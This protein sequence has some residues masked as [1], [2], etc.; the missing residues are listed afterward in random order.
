MKT[1][2]RLILIIILVVLFGTIP[3]SLLSKLFEY[4]SIALDW[5]AQALNIWGWQGIV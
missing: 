2:I 3:L 1:L 5:L 4:I